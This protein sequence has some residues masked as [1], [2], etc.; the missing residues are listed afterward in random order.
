[1]SDA[2]ANHGRDFVA[3]DGDPYPTDLANEY[4]GT[5]VA[6]I[7]GAVTDNS[8][9]VAGISDCNLLSLRTL[10][11]DVGYHSDIGRGSSGRPTREST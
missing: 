11:K 5:H 2:V 6:G 3:D 9:G 7:A 4:H 10:D 1:M 8:E